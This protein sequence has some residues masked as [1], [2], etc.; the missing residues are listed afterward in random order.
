MLEILLL[1]A[2]ALRRST[3][4]GPALDIPTIDLVGLPAR[5]TTVRARTRIAAA[6]L[7]LIVA[8]PC[9]AAGKGP[10][11]ENG[12]L[13]F[14]VHDLEGGSIRQDD[15]RWR[16]KV[17][18]IN[19]FGTWCSPCLTE[20]PTL[21]DLQSRLGAEGLTIT[22]IAF[23]AEQ[24]PAQRRQRLRR[25]VEQH[26]IVY[27]VLD[28]GTTE[29]LARSFPGLRNARGFPIEVLIDRSGAI[30][31]VRN[32]YGYKKRWARELERELRELLE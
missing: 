4:R 32:G 30:V 28:G 8:L 16:Q 23:E 20:I 19:L 2:V 27:D 12:P 31:A 11:F 9:V 6:A 10:Y 29:D 3:L 5:G 25:F 13:E 15:E 21:N 17:V 24:D 26:G 7:T 18:L 1:P 22:A 14:A